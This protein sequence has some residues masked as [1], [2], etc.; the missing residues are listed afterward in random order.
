MDICKRRAMDGVPGGQVVW[1]VAKTVAALEKAGHQQIVKPPTM[2]MP[3]MT[4]LLD[5]SR[6][7]RSATT[8]IWFGAV[9]EQPRSGFMATIS[10][11]KLSG[12]S[13][14]RTST[15]I[16]A[17][18]VCVR[19]KPMLVAWQKPSIALMTRA[20]STENRARR[21]GSRCGGPK[22]TSYMSIL[23]ESLNNIVSYQ[24]DFFTSTIYDDEQLD[25]LRHH[26]LAAGRTI[27]RRVSPVSR[28]FLHLLSRNGRST[29]GS[30]TTGVSSRK[31]E[32]T[33][34]G[35]EPTP[36]IAIPAWLPGISI[37]ATG[38]SSIPTHKP[39]ER[40]WLAMW[41]PKKSTLKVLDIDNKQNLVGYT[42]AWE[43]AVA[44]G[45]PYPVGTVH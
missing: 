11:E 29:S 8:A 21:S 44:A 13:R 39:T 12:C 32:N 43:G 33:R 26:A 19:A 15:G 2:P 17:K 1:N 20:S 9:M 42:Q 16:S 27:S 10:P 41:A 4:S 23:P 14:W 35:A 22:E 28:P 7:E 3:A 31:T 38:N 36:S 34:T 45:G 24:S 37:P 6:L 25:C 18:G 30:P 5:R 40:Y